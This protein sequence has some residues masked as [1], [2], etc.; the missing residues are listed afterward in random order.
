MSVRVYELTAER[1]EL[2][3]A[4]PAMVAERLEI[5]DWRICIYLVPHELPGSGA[6]VFFETEEK[7]AAVFLGLSNHERADYI[8]HEMGHLS[9]AV[10]G[11][12]EAMVEL[13]GRLAA[14]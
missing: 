4:E 5:S 6:E 13:L 2:A 7:H 3:E 11:D 12:E 9:Y 1:A 8:R 10:H 14:R